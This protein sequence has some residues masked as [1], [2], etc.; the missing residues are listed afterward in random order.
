MESH[1]K[2]ES[3]ARA[4]DLSAL[5]DACSRVLADLVAASSS[6]QYASLSLV[7]GRSF[8]HANGRGSADAARVAAVTT[9]LLGI[10]GAFAK[11]SLAGTAKH[12]V[13]AVDTGTIAVVRVPSERRLF[14]LSV[15]VG[16]DENLAFVMRWTLDASVKLAQTLDTAGGNY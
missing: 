15:C 5:R 9:S 3:D 11:E 10:S 13:I 12:T 2:T 1:R 16:K 6:V 14:A 4:T 7:D 8:A